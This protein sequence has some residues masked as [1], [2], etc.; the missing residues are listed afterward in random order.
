MGCTPCSHDEENHPDCDE[1]REHYFTT[2]LDT[3]TTDYQPSSENS[4]MGAGAIVGI[5]I[6]G[7]SLFL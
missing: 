2:V 7:V 4:T 1:W 5:C 6:A 3:V